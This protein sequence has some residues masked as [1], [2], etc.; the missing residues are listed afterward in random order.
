[1]NTIFLNGSTD[2][3]VRQ[4]SG[5]GL[6]K[7]VVAHLIAA[8]FIRCQNGKNIIIFAK[9]LGIVKAFLHVMMQSHKIDGKQSTARF[10]FLDVNA[11][12]TKLVVC[13][14]CD[15]ECFIKGTSALIVVFGVTAGEAQAATGNNVNVSMGGT[16]DHESQQQCQVTILQIESKDGKDGIAK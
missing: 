15:C 13:L 4:V 8:G 16:M 12:E 5:F 14:G 9:H 10:K 6:V 3:K 1:M 11:H 7:Q 2:T